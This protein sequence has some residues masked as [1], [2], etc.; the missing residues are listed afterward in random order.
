MRKCILAAVFAALS[1]SSA[2]AADLAAKAYT[3]APVVATPVYN[4]TGFYVGGHA[5][6][7][8]SPVSYNHV[9]T[10]GLGS[11]E[12]FSTEASGFSGGAQIGYQHQFLN[13]WVLGVEASYSWQDQAESARTNLDNIPRLR[14]AKLGDTW[15]IAGR[16][17]YAWGAT[18][19]YVKGGYANTELSFKNTRISTGAILGES[20]TRTDGYVVGAG[21]AYGITPNWSVGGEYNYYDFRPGAQQQTLA[22]QPVAAYNDNIKLDIHQ[23]LFK[24][25]YR[26]GG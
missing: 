19:L 21:V 8:W 3:K 6:Y 5:G 14:E 10:F 20:S 25:N 22:G 16:L 24:L 12:A 4:W 11:R 17:G 18:L 26:F 23:V 13:S 7:A 1:C 2:S 15:A 9:E